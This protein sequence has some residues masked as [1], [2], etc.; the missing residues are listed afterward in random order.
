M[1]RGRSGTP[2]SHCRVQFQDMTAIREQ[3]NDAIDC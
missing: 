2:G 3:A 1:L